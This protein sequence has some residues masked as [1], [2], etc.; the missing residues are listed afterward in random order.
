MS[1]QKLIP[2]MVVIA[3][4]VLGAAFMPLILGSIDEGRSPT[5]PQNYSDQLNGTNKV[6]VL[7]VSTTKFVAPI[8]GVVAIVMAISMFA[9]KR[10]F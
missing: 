4:M 9:K 1:V 5:M 7:T 3:I 6:N 2:L 8:L 10:R